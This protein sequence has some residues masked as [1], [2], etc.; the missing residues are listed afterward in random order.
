[1]TVNKG[2]LFVLSGPSGVGKA[3]ILSHFMKTRT[4]CALSISA[5]TRPCRKEKEVDGVHYH[6]ISREEFQKKL[7][8]GEMLE[9][10]EYAGHLYGTP[11]NPMTEQRQQGKHVILEIEVQGAFQV[12]K[13]CPDAVLIFVMPPDAQSLLDRLKG[14]GTETGSMIRTR[15][16]ASV[17]EMLLAEMYDYI[18]VNQN[19]DTCCSHLSAII[20]A[21]SCQPKHMRDILVN[22]WNQRFPEETAEL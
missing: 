16:Q 9:H 2:M 3:T 6:F 19:I 15:M 5:T 4:D 14:R 22:Y 17:E 7:D 18:V 21:A 11:L 8:A 20:T 13:K 1:M 10:A 12:R